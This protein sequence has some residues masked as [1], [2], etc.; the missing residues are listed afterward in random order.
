MCPVEVGG[1]IVLCTCGGSRDVIHLSSLSDFPVL[2][3]CSTTLSIIGVS[4]SRSHYFYSFHPQ[5]FISL[6][7]VFPITMKLYL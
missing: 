4:L 6:S 3:A 7:T 5:V 1:G 2:T